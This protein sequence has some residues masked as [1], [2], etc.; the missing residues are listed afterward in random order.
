MGQWSARV[1]GAVST[2]NREGDGGVEDEGDRDGWAERELRRWWWFGE[3]LAERGR[4]WQW[5]LRWKEAQVSVVWWWRLSAGNGEKSRGSTEI[6]R[7]R[8]RRCEDGDGVAGDGEAV[9][10]RW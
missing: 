6:E 1:G 7:Q 5:W 9:G 2:R 3:G 8:E 4:G 10:G